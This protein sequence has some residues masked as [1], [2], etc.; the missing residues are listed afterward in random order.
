MYSPFADRQTAAGAQFTEFAGV[1]LPARFG[2]DMSAEYWACRERVVMLDATAQYIVSVKGPGARLLLQRAATRDVD[3]MCPGCVVLAALC[4]PGGLLVD[5]GTMF[6]LGTGR[7]W[8]V[9]DNPNT[10]S[11]LARWASEWTLEVDLSA[12]RREM[13][14][15]SVQGPASRAVLEGIIEAEPGWTPVRD[16]RW[17]EAC[18]ASLTVDPSLALVVSRTGFTGELGYE[19]W[20]TA[21]DALPLWDLISSAGD[22]AGLVPAGIDVCHV[23]RV[24]AGLPF[25]GIDYD[26]SCDPFE[27]GLGRAVDCRKTHDY[28]GNVA[29]DR[30]RR[31]PTRRLVGLQLEVG[32]PPPPGSMVL[33]EAR[34]V[35]IITSS[36]FSPVLRSS[37]AFAMLNIAAATPG[38]SVTVETGAAWG[39]IDAC[40]GALRGYDPCRQK[41]RG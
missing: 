2:E 39:S 33:H 35:G 17:F 25:P 6:C 13:A 12:S 24:E 32:Q 19:L 1:A 28:L 26:Q 29:L 37:L 7:Y 22:A 38:Q 15:L 9:G 30:R 41:I 10:V 5:L 4:G 36:T 23:L 3:L 20:C 31:N 8:F 18:R 40:V 34:P 27:A 16:L 21:S 11:W 14:A